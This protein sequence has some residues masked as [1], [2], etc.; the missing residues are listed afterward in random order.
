MTIFEDASY[1]DKNRLNESSESLE[2]IPELIFTSW[3]EFKN[4]INRFALKE[5]FDYKI[6]TSEKVQGVVRRAVY[7]CTKSGSH[8]SQVTSN[9]TK[10][11][12]A[13]LLR[14]LCP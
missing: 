3:D 6:R 10:R 12:N 5:G 7:E 11:R 8:V 9:L 1:D 14:T 2:L 4:W 13:H